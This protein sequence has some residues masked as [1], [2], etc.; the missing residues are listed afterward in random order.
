[1]TKEEFAASLNGR[2]ARRFDLTKQEEKE[3]KAHGLVVAF[4]Y[5][6]DNLE[7]RGAVEEEV[8]CWNGT[9]AVLYKHKD[10]WCVVA[11]DAIDDLE[12]AR[13]EVAAMDAVDAGN[14]IT[15][16]W[17]PKEVSLRWLIKTSLP[18]AS[19]DLMEDGEVY[20]RAIVLNISDLK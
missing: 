7:F 17:A 2:D 8:G 3:A 6:D 9:T 16:V 13:A 20:D 18:S 5:S 10:K 19:F 1:M 14:S 12:N 11:T 15:A 4:G